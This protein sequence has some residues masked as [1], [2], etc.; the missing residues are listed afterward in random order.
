MIP[1]LSVDYSVGSEKAL[2]PDCGVAQS[3]QTFMSVD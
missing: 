1:A 2:T 3:D